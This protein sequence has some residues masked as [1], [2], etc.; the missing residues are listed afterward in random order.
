MTDIQAIS[1]FLRTILD[2]NPS[3][4]L[5]VDAKV[6]IVAFNKAAGKLVGDNSAI[7]LN[8]SSGDALHCL[9]S[10]KTPNG[11]G[12]SQNCDSCIIRCSVSQA[13]AGQTTYRVRTRMTLVNNNTNQDYFFLVTASPFK[14]EG[15]LLVHL[16]L[17]DITE[18][19]ELRDLIPICAKC[20]KIRQDDNYWDSV[21]KFMSKYLDLTFTHGYCPECAD[22]LL[23]EGCTD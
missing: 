18:F 1:S 12:H 3:I 9:N 4:V 10:T 2:A 15:K 22:E 13:I 14:Y 8:Q 5:I 20:K 17:E 11:C 7:M 21:E 16:V 6:R 23:N 19:M